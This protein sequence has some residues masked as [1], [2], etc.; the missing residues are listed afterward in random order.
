M[1]RSHVQPRR[2]R[3]AHR[4]RSMTARPVLP[5]GWRLIGPEMLA[6][7][8]CRAYDRAPVYGAHGA[9][10]RVCQRCSARAWSC[11]VCGNGPALERDGRC[12]CPCG[13]SG[14]VPTAANPAPKL[15]SRSASAA[16]VE[17]VEVPPALVAIEAKPFDEPPQEQPG[18]KRRTSAPR[19]PREQK[20]TPGQGSLF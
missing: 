13:W 9:M 10:V 8:T 20:S 4:W 5:E 19:K 7:P 11:P 18:P 17:S 12:F 14:D 3:R 6:C 2:G 16:A 1:R 15:L